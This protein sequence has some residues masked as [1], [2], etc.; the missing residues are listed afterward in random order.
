MKQIKVRNRVIYK[1]EQFNGSPEIM[2]K[3]GIKKETSKYPTTSDPNFTFTCY[4]SNQFHCNSMSGFQV[5]DWFLINNKNP[6]FI[7][8]IIANNVFKRD[9]EIV[10]PE[11]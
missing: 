11:V 5:K 8:K 10:K 2:E 7:D 6:N 1:A 9:Y 3:F 4:Y